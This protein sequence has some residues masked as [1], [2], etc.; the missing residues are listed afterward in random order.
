MTDM[1]EQ[2][3]RQ[4]RVGAQVRPQHATLDQMR[5]AW[6]AVEETGADTLFTWDHFFPLWGEPDGLHYEGFSLLAAMAEATERVELGP[7]VACN[8]YRNPNL[9]ADMA[10]TIDHISGGRFILGIGAGWFERD[11]R[12]Y[13]YDFGTA[14]DRLRALDAAMPVIRDRLGKLNP[15]PVRGRLPVMIGGGGEK[16]T[17]RIVAQHADIWNGFGQ[18]EEIGAKS[19]VLDD[20]CARTGRDPAG[21]ERSLLRGARDGIDDPDAY[22]AEGITHI[23]VGLDGPDYDLAPLRDLVAWRDA[24]QG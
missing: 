17:L 7:L 21:I 2:G 23:I 11:Y 13:G 22:V 9:L 5:R 19:R 6:L 24:R 8:T 1:A 10:R 16:V 15:G 4:I 18:P 20:W 12:E 3:R 14:P